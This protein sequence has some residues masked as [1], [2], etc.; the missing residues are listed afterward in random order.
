MD[1]MDIVTKVIPGIMLAAL[2][3]Y[4]MWKMNRSLRA[5]KQEHC[6]GSCQNCAH[7]NSCTSQ[8]KEQ[9]K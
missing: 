5:M 1:K 3:G 8:Q 4:N 2:V 7:K 6:S 9:E